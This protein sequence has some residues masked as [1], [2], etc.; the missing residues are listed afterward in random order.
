MF[1]NI[2]SVINYLAT[3]TDTSGPEVWKPIIFQLFLSYISTDEDYTS[4]QAKYV[5]IQEKK[6]TASEI[7]YFTYTFNVNEGVPPLSYFFPRTTSEYP[8][9]LAVIFP[10]SVTFKLTMGILSGINHTHKVSMNRLIGIDLAKSMLAGQP[11]IKTTF[12]FHTKDMSKRVHDVKFLMTDCMFSHPEATYWVAGLNM[13]IPDHPTSDTHIEL[14]CKTQYKGSG[15]NTKITMQGRNLKTL[16]GTPILMY[17]LDQEYHV[18]EYN[19]FNDKKSLTDIISDTDTILHTAYSENE[20]RKTEIANI[21]KTIEDINASLAQF[22]IDITNL[23]KT[24]SHMA[25]LLHEVTQSDIVDRMDQ[26]ES[27]MDLLGNLTIDVNTSSSIWGDLLGGIA[28]GA[29]GALGTAFQTVVEA[30]GAIRNTLINVAASTANNLLSSFM[31]NLSGPVIQQQF[32]RVGDSIRE[33]EKF[34]SI[35]NERI[36]GVTDVVNKKVA[37]ITD[38]LGELLGVDD[39][40]DIPKTE[41][42]LREKVISTYKKMDELEQMVERNVNKI[43][44]FSDKFVDNITEIRQISSLVHELQNN[45]K[46][47]RDEDVQINNKIAL[48][49]L[50]TVA[51]PPSPAKSEIILVRRIPTAPALPPLATSNDNT[52]DWLNTDRIKSYLAEDGLV[53][54]IFGLMTEQRVQITGM[55]A[56]I[57]AFKLRKGLTAQYTT[58]A[59]PFY[60]NNL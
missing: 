23:T 14:L 59:L 29:V 31:G 13:I 53:D 2:Q 34:Q 38:T 39:T 15:L 26:L 24:D 22:Q 19:W 25:Q 10:Q 37:D 44:T 55:E 7:D 5:S 1:V 36:K 42:P 27:N 30:K 16:V 33:N 46:E 51:S 12:M 47:L 52:S 11:A 8:H 32:D 54:Q 56:D 3:I 35:I 4:F 45:V 9:Q 43:K 50:S 40:E 57:K 17:F 28:G 48:Q 41:E 60:T 49:A 18:L 20:A 6:T 21:T 58:G